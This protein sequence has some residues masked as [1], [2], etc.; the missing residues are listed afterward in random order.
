MT[1]D[2]RTKPAWL[3]AA[4]QSLPREATPSRDLW[5]GI[6]ARIVGSGRQSWAI[7]AVVAAV[8]L[9]GMAAAF[10]YQAHRL[11][12]ERRLLAAAVVEELS[13]PYRLARADYRAAWQANRTSTETAFAAEVDLNLAILDAAERTLRAELEARPYDV[14]VIAL[15]RYTIEREV[16]LLAEVA[17]HQ[18][19]SI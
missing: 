6:A 9:G 16:D 12:A 5:P 17:R 18:T 13:A 4:L 15:L 7:A 3:E 10:A 8:T 11:E 19:P 14:E 2:A 1:D